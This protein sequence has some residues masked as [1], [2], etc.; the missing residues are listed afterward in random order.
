MIDVFDEAEYPIFGYCEAKHC[1]KFDSAYFKTVLCAKHLK[2]WAMVNL[3]LLDFHYPHDPRAHN[4]YI[5]Y[6]RFR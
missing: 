4:H 1:H 2:L 5:W 3:P 6:K